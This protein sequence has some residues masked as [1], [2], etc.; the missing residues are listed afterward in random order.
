M[1]KDVWWF[2]VS[3]QSSLTR[4]F[5]SDISSCLVIYSMYACVCVHVKGKH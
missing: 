5:Q 3:G 1:F 4:G 2:I